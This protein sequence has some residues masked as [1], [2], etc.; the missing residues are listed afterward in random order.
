MRPQY[1]RHV[2]RA[3]SAL[4]AFA[5]ALALAAVVTLAAATPALSHSQARA[6]RSRPRSRPKPR[7][8]HHVL[9]RLRARLL[10]PNVLIGR[11]Y[12]FIGVTTPRAAGRRISIEAFRSGRWVEVA[13]TTTD[14][15]GYFLRRV[16]PH[17]LGRVALRVRAAGV[18]A[19]RTTI[20]GR[21]ATVYHQ[22][23]A[24]W[25]GPGGTTACGE[26]LGAG[27]LGVA[28]RTLP[29]GTMVTLRLGTRTLRV[30]VIDRGPY[31]A[32]RTYDLT[33]ATRL[34]LGASDVAT[35]WASA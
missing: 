16:W 25:Y 11:D 12:V 23:V 15:D 32:G 5:G 28:N 14:H 33:Y 31:V 26:A 20:A 6:S 21:I 13:H 27:T 22:V 3:A 8:R 10:H 9:M 2:R 1:K 29:C 19:S 18:P 7:P 17:Q 4:G 30:P 34:A 24:S 35:L